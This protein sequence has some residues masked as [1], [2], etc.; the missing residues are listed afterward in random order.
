MH[1]HIHLFLRLCGFWRFLDKHYQ[2]TY[3]RRCGDVPNKANDASS[4]F[5]VLAM[6]VAVVVAGVVVVAA[7]VA[8]VVVR[9]SLGVI[10]CL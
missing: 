9:L 1:T 8:L 6:E 3:Q 4:A 2:R 7:V 5:R 10:L